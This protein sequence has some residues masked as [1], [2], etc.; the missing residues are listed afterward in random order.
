MAP[1]QPVLKQ[2]EFLE[3]YRST[4]PFPSLDGNN[5]TAPLPSLDVNKSG[6]DP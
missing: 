4:A 6:K 5:S 1:S 2:E 3:T